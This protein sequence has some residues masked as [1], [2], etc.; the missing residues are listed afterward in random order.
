M[1][2]ARCGSGARCSQRLPFEMN[3]GARIAAV[4]HD[5]LDGENTQSDTE[6][7]PGLPG[8]SAAAEAARA[9]SPPRM[10]ATL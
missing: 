4:F 8:G 10:V 2:D 9:P 5:D 1:G 3:A 6:A 7:D